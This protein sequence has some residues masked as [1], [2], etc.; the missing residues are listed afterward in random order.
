MSVPIT[1]EGKTLGVVVAQG[2]DPLRQALEGATVIAYNEDGTD[3]G[4]LYAP[5][6][7]FDPT[8]VLTGA[9]WRIEGTATWVLADGSDNG[10]Q[11]DAWPSR[12]KM[13]MPSATPQDISAMQISDMDVLSMR[14]I[15]E[16]I[17]S[18]QKEKNY[19]R[20]TVANLRIRI[21]E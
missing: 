10:M 15:R 8:K 9:G 19:P 7:I 2:Y 21:L 6:L 4:F 17:V 3:H 16:R 14:Q 13:P 1:S 11:K 18:M 12:V 5:E 20:D